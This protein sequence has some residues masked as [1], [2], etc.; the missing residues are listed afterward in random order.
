M[1]VRILYFISFFAITSA[2]ISFK[3]SKLLTPR[4]S[5]NMMQTRQQGTNSPGP[6]MKPMA[7][8]TF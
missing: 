3:S 1:F 8:G 7:D 2:F 5:L 4:L 6:G